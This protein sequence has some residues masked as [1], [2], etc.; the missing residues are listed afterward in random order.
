MTIKQTKRDLL[1][2]MI[3]KVFS[4]HE[5]RLEEKV[6]SGRNILNTLNVSRSNKVY[7]SGK[8]FGMVLK[9]CF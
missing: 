3:Y 8:S 2:A 9:K 7:K 6:A 4:P 1:F 5:R